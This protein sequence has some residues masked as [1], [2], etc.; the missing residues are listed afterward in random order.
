MVYGL[1]DDEQI[2]TMMALTAR[3]QYLETALAEASAQN[4]DTDFWQ[5]H[6]TRAKNAYDKVSGHK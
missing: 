2:E 5:N 3:I 1:T 6:L 4:G